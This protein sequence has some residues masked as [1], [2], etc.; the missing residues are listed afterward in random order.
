LHVCVHRAQWTP[1]PP[2]RWAPDA[3]TIIETSQSDIDWDRLLAQAEQRRLILQLESALIY[4]RHLLDAPIPSAVLESL[5]ST[6]VSRAERLEYQ[7]RTSPPAL[8]SVVAKLYFTHT[9]A[10]RAERP[11]ALPSLIA[12]PRSLQIGW[13]LDHVWQVPFYAA[14]RVRQRLAEAGRQRVV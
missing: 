2:L 9:R 3:L 7:S 12:F 14:S 8:A 6:P 4:L 13:G 11:M 5:R 10:R 1:V